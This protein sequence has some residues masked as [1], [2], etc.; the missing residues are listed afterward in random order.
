[1]TPRGIERECSTRPTPPGGHPRSE[2]NLR[3]LKGRA[4]RMLGRLVLDSSDWN[5]LHLPY[6]PLSNGLPAGSTA[7]TGTPP[8]ACRPFS[9]NDGP[10][11]LDCPSG[12]FKWT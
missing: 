1:M 10:Y 12:S 4:H 11:H 8:R 6:F 5:A 7:G 3:R 9:P 2:T